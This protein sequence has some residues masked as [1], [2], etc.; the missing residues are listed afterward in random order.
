MFSKISALLL[1]AALFQLKAQS[2]PPPKPDPDDPGPPV[3]KRGPNAPRKAPIPAAKGPNI[4]S[5]N[6]SVSELAP[7]QKLDPNIAEPKDPKA[8]RDP[9]ESPSRS[10]PAFDISASIPRTRVN[11]P[12][13][14]R[15][16]EASIDYDSTLPNFICDEGVNRM[17]SN[18]T[19]PKWKKEDRVDVE[20]MYVDRKEDYRNVR[21]NGKALKPGARPEDT[22]SWSRGDWGTVLVDVLHPA[23]D[24]EF[25]KRGKDKIAGIDCEVYDFTVEKANSHWQV[26]YTTMI[27]PAYKGAIWVDPITARVL[28]IEMQGRRLPQ[29]YEL[30]AVELMIEYGWVTIKGEKYLLPTKSE[31]LSCWRYTT[32]CSMNEIE[33]KN[34]RRFSTESS[35]STTES[36]INFGDKDPAKPEAPKLPEAPAKKKKP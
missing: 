30:D 31:N 28:R 19:P 23:T 4:I 27:K 17:M 9:N 33:F 29:T 5:G 32:R 10:K 34:Y 22:G 14:A 25:K 35:I 21:I 20:V 15:A 1:F 7:E 36:E 18:A 13:I 6:E 11:D 2:Q 12:L 26:Q 16:A 8:P 24:A 3:V